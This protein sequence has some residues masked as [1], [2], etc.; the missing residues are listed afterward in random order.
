MSANLGQIWAIA[1]SADGKVLATASE[2]GLRLWDV[3]A[4]RV[5][6]ALSYRSFGRGAAIAFSPDGSR[7]VAPVYADAVSLYLLNVDD[8][9]TLAR[10]KVTRGLSEQECRQYL[11]HEA[12]ASGSA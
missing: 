10:S 7:L 1:T 8:L 11:H 9:L 3:A 2:A 6:L 5:L 12:C 4:R